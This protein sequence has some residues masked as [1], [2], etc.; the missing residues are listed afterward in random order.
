MPIMGSTLSI[1]LSELG[2]DKGTIGLFALMAIPLSLKVLWTP[3]IDRFAL[4]F[5]KDNQRK[6]WIIF[7]LLGMVLCLLG[8]SVI[9]P[10]RSPWQLALCVGVLSLFT[11]CLYMAGISYELESLE[12]ERYPMGSAHLISGYRIGLLCAGG[13]ALY[14]SSIW[15]WQTTFR[16]AAL[17]PGF[18]AILILFL[19][20][21]YKSKEVIESKRAQIAQYSSLFSWFWKEIVWMPCKAIFQKC[22]WQ[23][24]FM[25]LL[26]F[27]VGDELSKSMEGPFYLSLG[28]NK[29]ELA[30]AA[31]TWGM[32]ATI[33]GAFCGGMFMK[34]KGSLAT[35]AKTGCLH[36]ST[37]YC[38]PVMALTGKSMAALYLTVAA[39]HFSA[40]LLM[41][42]FIA[43]LWKSCDKNYASMQYTL[44]WSVV[45]FKT[46]VMACLGGLMAS[47]MEWS[48]F[49]LVVA[50]LGMVSAVIPLLLANVFPY[51]I[52]TGIPTQLLS[53][54][55]PHSMS[56]DDIAPAGNN[57]RQTHR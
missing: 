9:D 34:G 32:V 35:L 52:K 31:K 50:T 4:P 25:M 29:A 57:S 12:K 49:F 46:D 8:M 41:T 7:S 55:H 6:G 22:E 11:C 17:L 37:L 30:M 47:Y 16:C 15:D 45:S 23:Q 43:Y 39:E 36:A 54:N 5:F 10:V 33:L 44:F 56:Y 24:I 21:P 26:L 18:G 3:F 19:P 42:A 13:G 28:F 48:T 14:L 40:G 1:W 20:E 51:K 2:Y 38:F 53:S 27:K